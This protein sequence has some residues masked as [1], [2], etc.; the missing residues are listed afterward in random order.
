MDK[1]KA[2]HVCH[3]L[4]IN[5]EMGPAG[6]RVTLSETNIAK[7]LG[8]Y[9]ANDLKPAVQCEQAAAKAMRV[10]RMIHRY[11]EDLHVSGFRRTCETAP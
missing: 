2:R 8:V 10:V 1:C 5:N 9:T 6:G 4:N 7:D 11:F 3:S